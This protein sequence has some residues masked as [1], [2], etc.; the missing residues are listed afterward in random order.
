MDIIAISRSTTKISP[1][2][3]KI[4]SRSSIMKSSKEVIQGKGIPVSWY[5][6]GQSSAMGSLKFKPL[7]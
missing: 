1:F 3:P 5:E 7:G 2:V 4:I 6:F